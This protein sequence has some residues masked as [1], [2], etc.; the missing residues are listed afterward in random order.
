MLYGAELVTARR[1]FPSSKMCSACGRLSKELPLPLRE[2]SR[3]C[4]A[5]HDR[6]MNAARN[7][8]R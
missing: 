7:L 2:W 8:R 4:G 6:D 1:W 3:E 5:F